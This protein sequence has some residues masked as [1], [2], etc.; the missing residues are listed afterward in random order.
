[1]PGD[2]DHIVRMF[3]TSLVLRTGGCFQQVVKRIRFVVA[4]RLHRPQGPPDP[5]ARQHNRILI[6]CL[7]IQL[8]KDII[9]QLL[10]FF[11]GY[12]WN[13]LFV[14]HCLD[15]SCC[16]SDEDCIDKMV[17]LLTVIVF[18]ARPAVPLAGRWM[19]A[20]VSNCWFSLGTILHGVLPLVL[21]C[22]WDV[23]FMRFTP[24]RPT[25][26]AEAESGDDAAPTVPDNEMTNTNDFRK[27]RGT[28]KSRGLEWITSPRFVADCLALAIVLAP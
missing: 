23:T 26:E 13:A 9:E 17:R 19:R 11:N 18:A 16:A 1:M 20:K 25:T 6:E 12:W 24:G 8:H 4:S 5:R 28:R 15:E 14:H 27:K 21:R 10:D 7:G 2:L 22:S 3:S